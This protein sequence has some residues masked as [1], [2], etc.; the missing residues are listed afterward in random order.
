M[1]TFKFTLRPLTPFATPLAG[2]TLFG[3]LCWAA[4]ERRGDR[5]LA[6][7][8]EGYVTGHPFLVV[9]DG[10][11]S[12][13]LPRPTTPDFVLGHAID[14]ARRKRARTHRWLP[15]DH[16]G[17]P[18]QRWIA[19][20]TASDTAKPLVLTQ[21]TINRYTGTTG[22]DQFAPRQV[23]RSFFVESLR[24]DIYVVFDHARVSV[25]ELHDLFE[26]IGM[27][28][29][30]RDASTGL[31]KFAVESPK[32]EAWPGQDEPHLHWLTLAPCMPDAETLLADGCYFLPL[33]R[34]GRHGNLAAV[35]DSPFKRPIMMMATGAM[36]KAREPVYWSFHGCGL[37]GREA[38][39][40]KIIPETVHQGYAP[41]VPLRMEDGA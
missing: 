12:G 21:N 19:E 39:L 3:H 6:E 18:V 27:H 32:E 10:F 4:R 24:L 33:T 16:M 20:L 22:T 23:E 37:G 13:L 8:L 7:L 17:E 36:L 14:P 29:Y 1:K 34:F 40:S 5:G 30:G 28:G 41:V 26:T 15:A 38:P 25:E 11:P 31:G 2:D 9:S 35:Q